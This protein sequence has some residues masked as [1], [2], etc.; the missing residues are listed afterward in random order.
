MRDSYQKYLRANATITGQALDPSK[1]KKLDQYKKYN[2]AE[3][4]DFLRLHLSFTA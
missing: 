1:R 3:Y 2:W 4:L